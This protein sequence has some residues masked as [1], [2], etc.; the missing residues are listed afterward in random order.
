MNFYKQQV[1]MS[2]LSILIFLLFST[3][4]FAQV[5]FEIQFL[6]GEKF[7][8]IEQSDFSKKLNNKYM[9]YI[10]R[11]VRGII[12]VLE[13]QQSGDRICKGK[14]YV[15]EETKRDARYVAHKIDQT[16]ESYFKI[17][18]DGNYII[19]ESAAYPTLRGFPVFPTKAVKVGEKWRAYGVRVVEP[20]RDGVFTEVRFYCEYE[21]KG[22][23]DL[24]GQDCDIIYAQYAMRYKAGDDYYGDERIREISG[25]HK[26]TI[27]FDSSKKRPLFM[28]D[29]FHKTYS[30]SN[31]NKE[32]HEGFILTWFDMITVMD[33][34][35]LV[36]E[37]EEDL[38]DLDIEDVTVEEKEEGVLLTINRIHFLPD[39]A[40][41]RPD[42]LYRLTALAEAL[43]KIEGRTF[44]VVGHCA[45]W[46]SEESQYILSL[47]RAKAIV[48]YLVSQ[49][50]PATRFIYEGRGATEPVATNETEEGRIKNR[51]VEIYILED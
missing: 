47:E 5:I 39:Q 49:G 38:E 7:T 28:R 46:G 24:N 23:G 25:S 44:L 26:V 40:V 18:A 17:T 1:K 9:G 50:I 10:N 43:K 4:A 15:F 21:Y 32:K 34:T 35:E 3:S 8:L 30:Y 36:E 12:Q 48:D 11:T 22:K 2:V 19:L 51:R 45:K 27:Y 31:S 14:F 20:L 33:R 6:P 16:V 37:I 13:E 42:D 29:Q 41:V